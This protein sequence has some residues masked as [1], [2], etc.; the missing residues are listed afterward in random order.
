MGLKKIRGNNKR[1]GDLDH[2]FFF[3]ISGFFLNSVLGALFFTKGYSVSLSLSLLLLSSV[4][5]SVSGLSVSKAVLWRKAWVLKL[6]DL[7]RSKDQ[8]GL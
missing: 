3:F 5:V 6:W 1:K 4:S 2:N 7:R 8:W